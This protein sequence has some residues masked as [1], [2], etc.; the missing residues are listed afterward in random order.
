MIWPTDFENKIICGDCS[1]IIRSM[2]NESVDLIFTDPPYLK[3]F[4]NTYDILAND[5]ARIMKRGA[6]LVTI[7]GHF[8]LPLITKKFYDANKLKYRWTFCM[9]QFDGSHPR[10]AMGI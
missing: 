1:S 7:V 2:P 4:L 5:C 9:N 8:A 10:M 3:S 6:S